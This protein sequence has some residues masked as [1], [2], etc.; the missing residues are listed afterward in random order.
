MLPPPAHS[1]SSI[2]CT[3]TFRSPPIP[4]SLTRTLFTHTHKHTGENSAYGI[5]EPILQRAQALG[6]AFDT[7]CRPSSPSP[8]PAA[9]SPEGATTTTAAPFPTLAGGATVLQRLHGA[10]EDDAR[11]VMVAPGFDPSPALEG[12]ACVYLLHVPRPPDTTDTGTSSR[13]Q[14]PGPPAWFY[15]GETESVRRRLEQHRCVGGVSC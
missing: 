10:S 4:S 9:P 15:V 5:P 3:P 1:H 2:V 8:V 12:Q 13:R 11:A 7:A 14:G 6:H